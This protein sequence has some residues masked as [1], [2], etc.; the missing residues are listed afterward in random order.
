MS[1]DKPNLS[2]PLAVS[3][4]TRGIAG[5]TNAITSGIDQRKINSIYE[6]ITNALT[7]KTTLYLCKRP[8]VAIASDDYGAAANVGYLV[9]RGAAKTNFAASSMW[10]FSVNGNDVI[11]TDNTPTSTTIFTAANY[12]PVYVD[13]TSVSGTDTL[14]LQTRRTTDNNQRTWFATAIASWTEITDADLPTTIGKM[15]FMDGYAFSAAFTTSRI[16]NSDLNSLAN[17]SATG[18]ITKQIAQDQPLGLGKLGQQIIAFGNNTMEVFRNV[19]NPA[20]SPLESMPGYFKKAGMNMGVTGT[21]SHYYA[22]LLNRMYF[23]GSVGSSRGLALVMYDGTN[24]EK[25]SNPDIEK[26]ISQNGV[27][28]VRNCMWGTRAAIGLQLDEASATTHRWLMFFPDWKEWFE[29]NSTVVSPVGMEGNYMGVSGLQDKL[30]NV[31]AASDN[32]QDNGTDYTMTHQFKLP[33]EGNDRKFMSMFGV[34]GDTAR[35]ASTLNVEFSDD[36][37]QTFQTARGIDMTSKQKMLFRCGSY[38]DRGVRL[39]HT[40]NLDCRLQS[41]IARVG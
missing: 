17:W 7:G 18:Y 29:F 10:V 2:L 25:V 21:K 39:T 19:G 1:V 36:D 8:G 23:V 14:V 26:I 13:S 41:V 6:P 40:G 33:T 4:N 34:V 37:W 16:Y 20:G 30:Y 3:Y 35:S 15:E 32:W 27:V 9:H 5:F 38:H 28:A 22:V 24:V 12:L 11:A 31:S